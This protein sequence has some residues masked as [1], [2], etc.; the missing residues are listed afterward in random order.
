[1]TEFESLVKRV[2]ELE[3]IKS[4]WKPIIN[5]PRDGSLITMPVTIVWAAYKP[6]SEQFRKGIKGRWQQFNGY[7]WENIGHEPEFYSE[8]PPTTT[9]AKQ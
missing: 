5:A 4:P 9:G 3:G 8:L 1:M 7:G 2:A 6:S